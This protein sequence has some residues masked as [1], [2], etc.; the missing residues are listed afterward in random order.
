MPQPAAAPERPKRAPARRAT[1][2]SSRERKA[3]GRG[4]RPGRKGAASNAARKARKGREESAPDRSPLVLWGGIGGGVLIL[5]LGAW[6]FFGGEEDP[7]PANP[8]ANETAAAADPEDAGPG[9]SEKTPPDQLVVKPLEADPDPA[10]AKTAEPEVAAG[11]DPG[12]DTTALPDL[13]PLDST[14][15]EEWARMATDM[16]TALTDRGAAGG[17]ALRRLVGSGRGAY[18]A[19]V[20]ALKSLDLSDP[21]AMMDAYPIVI[22]LEDLTGKSMTWK[23]AGDPDQVRYN[24]KAV[25]LWHETWSKLSGSEKAWANFT[26]RVVTAEAAAG[27]DDAEDDDEIDPEELLDDL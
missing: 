4:S 5:S 18:P 17:R 9:K 16:S 21:Q 15:P 11:P 14:S 20:N 13:D 7:E 3:S 8:A 2:R 1:G 25:A 23:S 26:A 22:A 12:P 24:R 27:L 6:W 10:P 19:L